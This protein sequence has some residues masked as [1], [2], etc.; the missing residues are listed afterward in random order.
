MQKMKESYKKKKTEIENLTKA[1]KELT[2]DVTRDENQILDLINENDALKDKQKDFYS[3][4]QTKIDEMSKE[5]KT[6]REKRI[7]AESLNKVHSILY[8]ITYRNKKKGS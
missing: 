4:L 7:N 3:L 6:E 5:L 2:D 1:K 8:I